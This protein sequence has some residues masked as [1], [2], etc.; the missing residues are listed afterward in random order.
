MW[1]GQTRKLTTD[2]WYPARPNQHPDVEANPTIGAPANIASANDVRHPLVIFSPG[3]GGSPIGGS[4][5]L[6]EL[7]T[8]GFVVAAPE[9]DDCSVPVSSSCRLAPEQ[10]ARRPDDI[11]SV[12]DHVLALQTVMIR[13]S[14]TWLMLIRSVLRDSRWAG[15]LPSRRSSRPISAS[16]QA[17]LSIRP[18]C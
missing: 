7:A 3:L 5:F 9:H 12:L 14:R 4:I 18:R 8:H 11:E 6:T 17:S 1:D 13:Y 16:K 10:T 2:I 15:G